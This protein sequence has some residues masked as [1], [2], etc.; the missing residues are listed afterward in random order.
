[1]LNDTFD[2]YSEDGQRVE[3]TLTADRFVQDENV[4]AGKVAPGSVWG[5]QLVL[6]P[7]GTDVAIKYE[8][9]VDPSN[10]T[11]DGMHYEITLENAGKEI[12]RTAENKYTGIITL[13]EAQAGQKEQIVCSI[14]WDNDDNNS[15][16]DTNF[17]STFGQ[18]IEIPLVLTCTQYLGE[19]LPPEYT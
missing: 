12:R 4:T 18:K 7:T 9:E 16:D 8:I 13:S 19:E 1:M 10:I 14:I 6:D 11:I 17:A 5:G 15:T 2:L 3:F